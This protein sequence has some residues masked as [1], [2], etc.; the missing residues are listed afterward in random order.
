MPVIRKYNLNV[1]RIPVDK[2]KLK[3]LDA[4]AELPASVDLRPN[5]PPVY[6]QGQLGICTANALVGVLNIV[7]PITWDL[8]CSFIIMNA[9]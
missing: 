2:L 8:G 7:S 4:P 6:D 5:C 3:K 9:N 1:T